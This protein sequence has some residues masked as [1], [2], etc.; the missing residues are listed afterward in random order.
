MSERAMDGSL[1][2][3]A[4]RDRLAADLSLVGPD[5]QLVKAEFTLPNPKGAGGSID[6]LAR[7]PA[8][9]VV[10]ELKKADQ[11]AR[12]ALHELEKYVGLLANNQGLR[13]DQL[14]CILVSTHWHEILL[15]F[16]AS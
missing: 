8:G 9:L 4:L 15:P 16:R 12:Q 3:A 6:I 14:R 2:E 5:L 10:I 13:T 7:D 11:T 1:A